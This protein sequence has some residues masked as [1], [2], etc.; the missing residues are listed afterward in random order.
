MRVQENRCSIPLKAIAGAAGSAAA[1]AEP[2]AA[3]A[4]VEAEAAAAAAAGCS[5]PTLTASELET[6]ITV[7]DAPGHPRLRAA[8]FAAAAAA[9]HILFFV[10]AADKPSIKVAAECVEGLGF[11]V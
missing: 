8:A 9:S 4:A 1:A 10:D 7:V 3:A 5:F 2:A 11:R 6:K